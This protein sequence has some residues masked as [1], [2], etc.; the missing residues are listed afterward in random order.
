MCVLYPAALR[1]SGTIT[2]RAGTPKGLY[3]TITEGPI[4]VC[5]GYLPVITVERV[6]EHSGCT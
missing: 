3:I 1:S 5:E 2:S 6:G 4:P